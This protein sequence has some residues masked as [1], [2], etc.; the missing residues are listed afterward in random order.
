MPEPAGGT[1]STGIGVLTGGRPSHRAL[2]GRD[3]RSHGFHPQECSSGIAVAKRGGKPWVVTK[4]AK[5]DA[6]PQITPFVDTELHQMVET[7]AL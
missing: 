2:K 7:L 3:E 5:Q 4:I 6:V 1:K